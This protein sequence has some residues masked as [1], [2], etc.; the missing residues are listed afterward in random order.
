LNKWKVSPPK[1]SSWKKSRATVTKMQTT[2]TPDDFEFII[3]ALNDTSLEKTEKQGV[4]KE[5]MY[6]II[7]IKLQGVQHALQSSHAVSTTPLPS[8]E[9]ELG[10]KPAQLCHLVDVTEARLRRA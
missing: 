2:L 6:D 4:K 9:Q 5:E 10:D 8:G 7:E 1:P 3:V